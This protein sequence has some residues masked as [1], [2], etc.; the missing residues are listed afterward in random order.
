M[1]AN[2]QRGEIMKRSAIRSRNV[3]VL[4]LA[5]NEAEFA[6]QW[7]NVSDTCD[8]RVSENIFDVEDEYAEVD[9]IVRRMT[10]NA[11]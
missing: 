3:P 2:R 7:A 6:A 11:N 10:H 4:P 1:L 9:I 8:D 5:W